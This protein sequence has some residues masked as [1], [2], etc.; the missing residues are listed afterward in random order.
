[1]LIKNILF[2]FGW[3]IVGKKNGGPITLL[4]KKYNFNEWFIKN[5]IDDIV[6]DFEKWLLSSE[7]FLLFLQKKIWE[8]HANDLFKLW[9]DR[10]DVDIFDCMFDFVKKLKILG[11]NCYLLSDTNEIHKG[12]NYNNW[13]YDIFDKVILSCDIWFS[14]KEDVKKHTT[15]FFDYALNKL[16]IEADESI[17]IDDLQEN[18]DVANKVWIKTILVKDPQQVISDL[19]SILG[20]D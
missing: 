17:F 4:E 2:D 10:S 18:C 20:I 14:K 6:L 3:V 13:F 9:L 5:K 8:E 7:D 16:N 12:I 11:Y 1:M 15:K 19:S